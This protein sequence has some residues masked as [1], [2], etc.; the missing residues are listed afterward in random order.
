[1]YDTPFC[2]EAWLPVRALRW[3]GTAVTDDSVLRSRC[4]AVVWRDGS[5]GGA[6]RGLRWRVAVVRRPARTG[7]LSEETLGKAARCGSVVSR[8]LRPMDQLM[9]S[10]RPMQVD[11]APGGGLR[12]CIGPCHRPGQLGLGWCCRAR[13][14]R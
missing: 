5:G 7:I 11:A 6:E 9:A 13:G 12:V 14:Y 3:R 4:P 2:G 10:S 1:V 8:I